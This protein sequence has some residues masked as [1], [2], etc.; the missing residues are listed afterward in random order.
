MHEGPVARPRRVGDDVRRVGAPQQRVQKDP[1]QQAVD[2]S[3]C[4]VVG[5]RRS[6]RAD[7]AGVDRDRQLGGGAVGAQHLDRPAVAE[8]QVVHGGQGVGG[9][10]AAGGVHPGAV[11]EER[12]AP[13]LVEGVPHGDPVAEA[14]GDAGGV[15]GEP[16]GGVAGGPAA[17]VLDGLRQV[18]VVE[19]GGGPDAGGEQLVDQ[20]VVEAGALRLDPGPGDREPVRGE[21]QLGHQA[22][23]VAVAPEVVAGPFAGVAVVDPA[24]GGGEGVPDRRVPA[25]CA[26]DLVGGG[27]GAPPEPGGEAQ[28]RSGRR[29]GESAHPVSM[30]HLGERSPS[31]THG[32]S[33]EHALSRV[34][35][36]LRALRSRSGHGMDRTIDTPESRA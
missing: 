29:F 25:V 8:Q 9:R 23:V 16:G 12:R 13:R 35:W 28:R 2:L 31:A 5:L 21:A 6:V 33:P 32:R 10:G 3:R 17:A 30:G 27:G 1:V 14:G 4:V 24:G 19:R 26:L 20:A 36:H 11:A 34:V 15:V 7:R 18:P 22:H